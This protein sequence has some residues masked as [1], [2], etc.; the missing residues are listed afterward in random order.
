MCRFQPIPGG[1]RAI[2]KSQDQILSFLF[3]TYSGEVSSSL[4]LAR[5]K[6]N[7]RKVPDDVR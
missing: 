6:R 5:L 2:R 3:T 1:S 4:W 7:L